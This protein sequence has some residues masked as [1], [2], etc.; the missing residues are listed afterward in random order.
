MKTLRISGLVVVVMVIQFVVPS[1]HGSSLLL[2]HLRTLSEVSVTVVVPQYEPIPGHDRRELKETLECA[3]SSAFREGGLA[4]GEQ[5]TGYYQVVI[6]YVYVESVNVLI[7]LASADLLEP[8]QLDRSWDCSGKDIDVATWWD[9]RL[10]RTA[11]DDLVKNLEEA[12]RLQAE[13]LIEKVH[14]A[15]AVQTQ[16][17]SDCDEGRE[18]S[19]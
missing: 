5:S 3:L 19:P 1:S 9:S 10:V 18:S 7:L 17:E 16:T 12:L 14:E 15:R 2:Q 8:A 13:Y 11:P 4:V 6:K